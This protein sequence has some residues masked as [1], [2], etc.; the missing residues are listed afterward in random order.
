MRTR[1]LQVTSIRFRLMFST[2]SVFKNLIYRRPDPSQICPYKSTNYPHVRSWGG[3]RAK[4][5]CPTIVHRSN[6][7]INNFWLYQNRKNLRPRNEECEKLNFLS[8]WPLFGQFSKICISSK[9]AILKLTLG[10][11]L[12]IRGVLG[13]SFFQDDVFDAARQLLCGAKPAGK[14]FLYR[15]RG[16]DFQNWDAAKS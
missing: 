1:G 6:I 8:F 12:A 2:F 11:T 10:V 5:W 14:S 7:P 16:F 3:R 13:R 4:R 9:K 15:F